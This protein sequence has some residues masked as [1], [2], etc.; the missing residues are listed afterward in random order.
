[1]TRANIPAL[2]DGV[3]TGTNIAAY[4]D[5]IRGTL[6]GASTLRPIVK[7][8]CLATGPTCGVATLHKTTATSTSPMGQSGKWTPTEVADPLSCWASNQMTTPYTGQYL[9]EISSRAFYNLS[10]SPDLARSGI[11]LRIGS[12]R[13]RVAPI[14][15]CKDVANEG[16]TQPVSVIVD[17]TATEVVSFWTSFITKDGAATITSSYYAHMDFGGTASYGFTAGLT[18][19]PSDLK[20]KGS[21]NIYYLDYGA[22]S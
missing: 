21:I 15:E 5:L 8:T 16:Y 18:P 17:L 14:L 1:M 20:S 6:N 2:E 4:H 12:T 22:T 10:N 3:T 9:I 13:Y 11:I 19:L 7:L